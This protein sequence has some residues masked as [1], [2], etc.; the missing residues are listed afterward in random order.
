MCPESGSLIPGVTRLLTHNHQL[1]DCVR[2]GE[3]L[4][5]LI[6]RDQE[7]ERSRE[8]GGGLG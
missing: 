6:H 1:R 7:R 3:S 5:L 4:G 8:G 2:G